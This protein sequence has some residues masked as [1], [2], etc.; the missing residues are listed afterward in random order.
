MAESQV[1]EVSEAAELVDEG[2]HAY[3]AGRIAVAM[4]RFEQALRLYQ[5]ANEVTGIADCLG[6]LGNCFYRLGQIRQAIDYG[7]DA[8]TL[9]RGLG[10]WQGV[11]LT[12]SNLGCYYMVLGQTPRAA[13]YFE[14]ALGLA[15]EWEDRRGRAMRPRF[16]RCSG[17]ATRE[18]RGNRWDR[19]SGRRR[20]AFAAIRRR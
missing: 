6:N 4:G 18:G 8:L 15:G 5:R 12:L 20:F 10:D 19:F 9:R 11:G 14:Q 3:E 2:I 16:A 17:R 1:P 7:E 13:E